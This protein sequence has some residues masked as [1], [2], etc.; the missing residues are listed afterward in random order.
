MKDVVIV[1]AVRTPLARRDGALKDIRPDDL[2][3]ITLEELLRRAGIAG[4]AVEDVV[5]GCVTQ[6]QEQGW[7]VARLAA[8][9][10]GLPVSVPGVTINRMCGSGQ[11]SI[12]FAAQ[13]I[14]SGDMDVAVAG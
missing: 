1:E 2:A 7:N 8:L 11:Q 5:I 10:A 4:D 13:A 12:H 9:N 3:A 6:V 14:L